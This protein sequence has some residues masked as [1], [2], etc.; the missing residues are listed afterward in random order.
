MTAFGKNILEAVHE[1]R[2]ALGG[3]PMLTFVSIGADKE[4]VEQQ[5][6][7][8]D[9][10]RNGSAI[11]AALAREHMAAGDA[12]ALIMRNHAEFVDCMIGSAMAG[13]VYVP[14]E[15]RMTGEKLRYMLV[16]ADCRGAV[17]AD[18]ALDNVLEVIGDWPALEWIWVVGDGAASGCLPRLRLLAMADILANSAMEQQLR[19]IDPAEPMQMLY[20]SGTT[21]DPKAICSDHAR[22]IGATEASPE[23]GLRKGDKLFT[24]LPLS[25]AN[26]QF[27]SLAKALAMQLPIVICERFTKSRMWEILTRYSCTTFTLLGGMTSAIYAQPAGPFDRAHKVRL[28]ISAGMPPAMWTAFGE[29]FSVEI[30]EFYGTAEGGLLLNRPGGRLGSV[31]KPLQGTRCA[32]LDKAMLPVPAGVIGELCFQQMDGTTPS[33]SYYKNPQASTEKTRGGWFHSGDMGWQ[34]G[35]GWFFFSHRDGAAIRRNGEFISPSEVEKVIAEDPGVEDVFVYG[36]RT[37][38]NAPGEHEVV[39][40]IVPASQAFDPAA[41]FARCRSVLAANSVPFILQILGEIPK[42][43]SEKPQRNQLIARWKQGSCRVVSADGSC[44]TPLAD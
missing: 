29:R 10:W 36:V 13:T 14:I 12:F 11:C 37:H 39:A 31:G 26:A 20:T 27:I 32:V 19:L 8:A 30:L 2:E 5:R 22:F 3:A 15:P 28:V 16:F 18:Y 40:A 25:H 41:I 35:A 17:V 24:G 7:Y 44:P 23:F 1:G 42:T 4:L 34:D 9:L 33:V 43:A 6:S 21:G 38:S